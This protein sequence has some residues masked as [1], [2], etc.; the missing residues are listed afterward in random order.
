MWASRQARS[1]DLNTGVCDNHC[2]LKLGRALAI[3]CGRCPLVLP[4]E[5]FPRA[6]VN[7]RLDSENMTLLH[8][9]DSF[10]GTI[11]GNS[12]CLMENSTNAVTGV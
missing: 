11:V 1:Q 6:L 2:V 4:G 3:A 10:V 12:R 9:A 8:E 5:I 7:H